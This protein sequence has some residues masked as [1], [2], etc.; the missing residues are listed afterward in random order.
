MGEVK[1]KK[2]ETEEEGKEGEVCVYVC[3][4]GEEIKINDFKQILSYLFCTLMAI[5]AINI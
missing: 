5:H 3:L 4:Y 1:K 2:L